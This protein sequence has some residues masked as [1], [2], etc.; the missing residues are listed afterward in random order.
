MVSFGGS[1]VSLGSFDEGTAAVPYT[2]NYKLHGREEI[3]PKY[4][5]G[6]GKEIVINI[7]NKITSSF[8]NAAIAEEPDTVIN[9]I[10]SDTLRNGTTRRTQKLVR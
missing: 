6:K 2:G 10:N 9:V 7:V 5:S 1:Q 8:V 3:V 4:D